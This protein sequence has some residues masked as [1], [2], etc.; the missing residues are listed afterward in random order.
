MST[1]VSALFQPL[2]VRSIDLQY[3]VVLAPLTRL[4]RADEDHIH[5]DTSMTYYEQRSRVPGT[6]LITGGSAWLSKEIQLL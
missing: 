1:F 4:L 5:G 2:C 6:L 3:R